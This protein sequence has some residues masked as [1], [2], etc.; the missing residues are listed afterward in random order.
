MAGMMLMGENVCAASKP[1]HKNEL[2]KENG[3]IYYYNKNG[4][5]IKKRWKTIKE[6]SYYFTA[7]GF[8]SV[9]P[10]KISG[11]RYLFS[12]SGVLQ[13][14]G[15]KK[16]KGKIYFVNAKGII[17]TG[18]KTVNGKRYYFDKSKGYMLKDTWISS[19]Y[20][21]KKGVYDAEK[22][23]NLK[24]LKSNMQKQIK[25]Y[26][27]TWSVYVKNLDTGE[28]FSINNRSMYAASL[29]KLYA[30]G[31]AYDKIKQGK[32]KESSV[33][34]QLNSMI[35]V[36]NN[37]SFNSIIRK[38]GKNY[39]NSWCEKNGYKQTNQGHG[40]EPSGNSAGLGNGTGSNMTSVRDCGKFLEEVYSGECVNKSY[41][42]KMLTLLKKQKR[43]SK[44]PAGI[45]SGVTVA[46]KTGETNSYAHD[47]AIVYSKGANY[48]ICV[49]VY[50]RGGGWSAG[51]NIPAL[52]RMAYRFFN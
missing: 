17:G 26:K 44:I 21:N 29:I 24:K 2:V 41:S 7:N 1:I 11:K 16:Y 47:A 38:V 52:S 37:G 43:R 22:K 40:L 10:T 31:A 5:R 27:G 30:M 14:N 12:S 39:V 15:L 6:K 28:S 18:W 51:Q 32:I 19:K 42:K 36:S 8:A 23:R 3:K 46:N 4:K 48:V 49:M 33:S 13:K 9:G 34:K 35:T 45:P 20:I 25:S 50:R